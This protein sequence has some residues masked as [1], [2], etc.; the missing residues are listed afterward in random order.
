MTIAV[1]GHGC[2]SPEQRE[3]GSGGLLQVEERAFGAVTWGIYLRYMYLFY[4]EYLHAGFAATQ[5][6]HLA[7]LTQPAYTE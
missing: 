6:E 3:L 7:T 1:V 5:G 2:P 4:W